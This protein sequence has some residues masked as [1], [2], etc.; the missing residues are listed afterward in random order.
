MVS[1]LS[2]YEK[3]R[4][5]VDLRPVNAKT[6]KYFWPMPQLETVLPKLSGSQYLFSIDLCHSYRQIPLEQKSQK[7][8]SFQTSEEVLTPTRVL[9]GQSDAVFH[10]QYVVGDE[11][12][13]YI[14]RILHWLDE[15]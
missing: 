6:E 2:L 9:H 7:C 1:K 13:D 5:T 3:Y 14:N 10:F 11:I 8:Q 4:F 12:R 15:L